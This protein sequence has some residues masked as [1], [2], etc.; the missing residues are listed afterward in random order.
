MGNNEYLN[1]QL[2]SPL[3]RPPGPNVLFGNRN[4]D[5]QA[6]PWPELAG[7]QQKTGAMSGAQEA[8]GCFPTR[9]SCWQGLRPTSWDS[10]E[11]R[12]KV[13]AVIQVL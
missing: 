11:E 9:H 2:R 12:A 10:A 4:A 8:F 5:Q 13:S 7:L 1:L 3:N 6:E